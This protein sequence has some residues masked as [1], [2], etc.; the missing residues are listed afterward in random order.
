MHR[1]AVGLVGRYSRKVANDVL[2]DADLVLVV[3]CRLGGMVTDSWRRP[4]PGT[5]I[6]HVD[7]DPSVLGTTYREELGVV[8]DA[9]LALRA[10]CD[11]LRSRQSV[12]SWAK[13][14]DEVAQLVGAW[15]ERVDESSRGSRPGAVHP[16]AVMSALRDA[17]APT[18]VLVTDTGYMGAWAG[19]LYPVTVPGRHFFRA[20]GSLGWSLPASVGVAIGS[21]QQ[22]VACV[23]GD[24]GVGYH[25]MELE[26]ALRCRADITV[27]V[28]NNRTMAFEY[29]GQ[30]LQWGNQ[31]LPTVND[32]L[33]VDYAEVARALGA[34]AV[35][36]DDV[37]ELTAALHE[38]L[39]CGRAAL[40]DVRTDKEALAPVTNFEA[41]VARDV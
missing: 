26:T 18:D 21:P 1:L 31:V 4:M 17:L 20:A 33:D 36:V 13:W 3:G 10:L 25:L 15:R 38:A 27:V 7:A 23:I 39:T 8:A 29:H 30:K 28:L 40:V 41:I 19:A 6:I 16:A 22:R 5:R 35:R 37:E 14:A 11:E 12:P 24:G 34:H 9:Q 32:F 2:G